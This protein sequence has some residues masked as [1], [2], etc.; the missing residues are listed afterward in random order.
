M[1]YHDHKFGSDLAFSIRGGPPRWKDV[2]ETKGTI[3]PAGKA[4]YV[5]DD[6]G[7]PVDNPWRAS[8]RFGGLDFFPDGRAALCTW[9]G[10][11]WIVSGLGTDKLYL[12]T[13]SAGSAS[14][15]DCSS[16]WA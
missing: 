9:D 3:A 16:R 12:P 1:E 7:L 8:I 15:R 14:P 10:D 4:P 11:V 5:V 13:R 2:I 6:I